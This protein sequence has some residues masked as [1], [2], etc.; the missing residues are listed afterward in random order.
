MLDTHRHCSA[1]TSTGEAPDNPSHSCRIE[2]NEMTCEI[3]GHLY[4]GSKIVCLGLSPTRLLRTSTIH[5]TCKHTHSLEATSK[6]LGS[7]GFVLRSSRLRGHQHGRNT[8]ISATSQPRPPSSLIQFYIALKP[9][10][11]YRQ[12]D[13]RLKQVTLVAVVREGDTSGAQGL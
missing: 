3:A 1:L 6:G 7:G 8:S 9:R 2:R 10:G 5:P 4:K 12:A 13:H 11:G